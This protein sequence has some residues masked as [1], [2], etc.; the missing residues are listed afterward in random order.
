MIIKKEYF[1]SYDSDRDLAARLQWL[2][3]NIGERLS[4]KF[5]Y[6]PYSSYHHSF[7]SDGK[8]WNQLRNEAA[9]ITG[10]NT[11]K[12][13]IAIHKGMGW[14][15]VTSSP[16]DHNSLPLSFCINVVIDHEP[17]AVMFKLLFTT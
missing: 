9:E 16:L 8:V 11:G 15:I 5:A 4:H 2:Y 1:S 14:A 13:S 10:D 17:T 3:D 6:R 12:D 7:W